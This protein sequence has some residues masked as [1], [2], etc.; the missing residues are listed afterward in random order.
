M[1]RR[2][3]TVCH[4]GQSACFRHARTEERPSAHRRGY[5]ARWKRLRD[6]VLSEEPLCRFCAQQGRI[7]EAT[8]V[9]HIV[10][11]AHD[12]TL[13]LTRTNLRALCKPCHSRHTNS[14]HAA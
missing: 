2:L 1:P 10:P 8:E 11:I 12:P 4:C 3:P 14:R 9:D 5:D 6:V 13:R 7:T